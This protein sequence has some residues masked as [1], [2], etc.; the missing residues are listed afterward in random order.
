MLFNTTFVAIPRTSFKNN[1]FNN[2][3][4]KIYLLY[5]NQKDL[6]LNY[7]KVSNI[8]NVYFPFNVPDYLEYKSKDTK[9]LLVFTQDFN[10]NSIFREDF[11]NNK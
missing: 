11:D 7:L 8:V 6:K 9:R 2:N 5:I 10:N 4:P 1:K 3:Y